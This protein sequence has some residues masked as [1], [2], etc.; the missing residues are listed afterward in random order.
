MLSAKWITNVVLSVSPVSM[1]CLFSLLCL[2]KSSVLHR[3]ELAL[4]LLL[5]LLLLLLNGN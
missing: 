4:V 3:C 1:D 5:L 2:M